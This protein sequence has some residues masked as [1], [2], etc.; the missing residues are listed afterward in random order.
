MFEKFRNIPAFRVT[1]VSQ[2]R[3]PLQTAGT[4]AIVGAMAKKP[5]LWKPADALRWRTAMGLTQVQAAELLGTHVNTIRHREKGQRSIS[6]SD[7]L[8]MRYIERYGPLV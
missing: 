6:R 4:V 5:K 3:P 2:A 1:P 7:A 8:L